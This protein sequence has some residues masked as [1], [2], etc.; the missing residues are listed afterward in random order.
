MCLDK[1]RQ[2]ASSLVPPDLQTSPAL[3]KAMFNQPLLEM[4]I[5]HGDIALCNLLWCPN[6]KSIV[7]FK[8]RHAE[9]V[10]RVP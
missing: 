4:G 10:Q 5:I 9:L 8:M 6:L 7:V 1:V 3:L 2:R